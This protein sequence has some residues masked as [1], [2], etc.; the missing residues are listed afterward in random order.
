M[1]E[2]GLIITEGFPSRVLLVV[3]RGWFGR[4]GK[5]KIKKRDD[6]ERGRQKRGNDHAK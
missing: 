5:M 4:D 3:F 1:R 6:R 2:G